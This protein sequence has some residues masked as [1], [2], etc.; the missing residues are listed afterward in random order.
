[1]QLVK[2]MTDQQFAV[3]QLV[4]S[5]LITQGRSPSRAQIAAYFGWRSPNAAQCALE[6]LQ[7]IGAVRLVA[8]GQIELGA[9]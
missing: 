2:K 6:S 3:L 4:R 8:R 7:V 9:P 5:L 1:M